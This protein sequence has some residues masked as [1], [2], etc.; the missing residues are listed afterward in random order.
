MRC[1]NPKCREVFESGVCLNCGRSQTRSMWEE[2]MQWKV[3]CYALLLATEYR[4]KRNVI[5]TTI[6][7]ASDVTERGG[8]ST[9]F[10]GSTDD[11]MDKDSRLASEKVLDF[12]QHSAHKVEPDYLGDDYNNQDSNTA[13]LRPNVLVKYKIDETEEDDT[14]QIQEL[15]TAAEL[16][17]EYVTDEDKKP[18]PIKTKRVESNITKVLCSVCGVVQPCTS[19][20]RKQFVLGCG[21]RRSL[22]L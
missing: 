22:K 4:P 2:W 20:E 12:A 9:R 16:T 1:L 18:K 13:L 19:Y 10:T 6:F 3:K 7:P 5:A 17:R 21:H 15:H 11:A 14:E 8:W